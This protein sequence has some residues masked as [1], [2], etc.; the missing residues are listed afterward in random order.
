[1]ESPGLHPIIYYS[2]AERSM[3]DVCNAYG[4]SPHILVHGTA[5]RLP[6]GEVSGSKF[7]YHARMKLQTLAQT[8][9]THI[10]SDLRIRRA[11][12]APIRNVADISIGDSVLYCVKDKEWHG[13]GVVVKIDSSTVYVNY[14][15]KIFKPSIHRVA[16]APAP[17]PDL[18][19]LGVD[20]SKIPPF[21]SAAGS[22]KISSIIPV[23]SVTVSTGPILVSKKAAPHA[24]RIA[25]LKEAMQWERKGVYELVPI[26]SV[27][28][29]QI[30]LPI[31]WVHTFNPH[32][33][34]R[35][36]LCPESCLNDMRSK[37]PI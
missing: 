36:Y 11:F 28:A 15:N 25:M 27:S 34:P 21:D 2:T 35:E 12:I 8:I 19:T 9:Q 1:M 32:V 14:G 6:I 37:M 23:A 4:L 13:P 5:R 10:Q 22:S 16:K 17:L 31:C 24:F 7:D 18:S 20:P 33:N 29:D 30:V 26:D 3:N